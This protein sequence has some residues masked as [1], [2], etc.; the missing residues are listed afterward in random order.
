MIILTFLPGDLITSL[1]VE[2]ESQNI[3]DDFDNDITE[4]DPEYPEYDPE[5][6]EYD[7]QPIL[8][9]RYM[10]EDCKSN[11]NKKIK[12]GLKSFNENSQQ[13]TRQFNT[14]EMVK[15]AKK[16]CDVRIKKENLSKYWT[17]ED[18][19]Y[20]IR[21]LV[22]P[23]IIKFSK[24]NQSQKLYCDDFAEE[25]K[26]QCA[27]CNRILRL[28]SLEAHVQN[29]HEMNIDK[30]TEEY[31]DP[32]IVMTG[33]IENN[34]IC[35]CVSIYHKC[36]ICEKEMA[37]TKQ[38]VE[39]HVQSNHSINLSSYIDNYMKIKSDKESEVNNSNV[40]KSKS[41]RRRITNIKYCDDSSSDDEDN[42]EK[43]QLLLDMTKKK[44][45]SSATKNG[46]A[47][48]F[49]KSD[50]STN[51]DKLT[52][53][54]SNNYEDCCKIE[55]QICFQVLFVNYL[56]GHTQSK[57][58][59][60][61]AS[62]KKKFGS[63]Y[64]YVVKSFHKCNICG[65]EMLF[66][67]DTIATHVRNKH[68]TSLK[69]Y[70][71]KYMDLNHK[72]QLHEESESIK[73]T[74]KLKKKK[75]SSETHK[76]KA[77]QLVTSKEN[78]CDQNSSSKS[79]LVQNDYQWFNGNTFSCKVCNFKST[80]LDNF[81]WH[82]KVDHNSTLQ[83]FLNNY[84][85]TMVKYE[86]KVCDQQIDHE[87]GAIK[88]HLESHFLS[89]DKYG[90]MYEKKLIEMKEKEKQFEKEKAKENNQTKITS[91]EGINDESTSALS[92]KTEVEE[93]KNLGAQNAKLTKQILETE[94]SQSLAM[95]TPAKIRIQRSSGDSLGTIGSG[96]ENEDVYVYLCP[97]PDCEFTTDF[98]VILSLMVKVDYFGIL[99]GYETWAC[100]R[101][102]YRGSSNRALADQTTWT[103]VEESHFGE[104]AVFHVRRCVIT[105]ILENL[106]LI[107]DG[108]FM[109]INILS[110][111]GKYLY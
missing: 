106:F 27:I 24:Q 57:H 76:D 98:Q 4:Y 73:S 69:D 40:V 37:M 94:D 92:S 104:K 72:R 62:Y 17:E 41:L 3:T 30:Y 33:V 16:R 8:N 79:K 11:E 42:K 45:I 101:A 31:G 36:K 99:Q 15:S 95:K 50:K 63:D 91:S 35:S 26:I 34:K 21:N 90:T 105:G 29:K 109:V 25:C 19:P 13:G 48:N 96:S 59:I 44:E 43:D 88:D 60:D 32:E 10:N 64:T 78:K 111:S 46:S 9:K 12:L 80:S 67:Q 18:K 7:P 65:S 6:P 5:F 23:S 71:F 81:K 22:K 74:S 85:R 66:D 14:K 28:S 75:Y 58:Q 2:R 38:I 52:R 61:I 97:F 103:E 47:D 87:K 56:R 110:F 86:C 70:N 54:Y 55:C 53:K 82:V 83:K 84:L 100:C 93:S 77:D 39:D 108:V 102:L 1:N 68:D 107:E 51:N 89:L 20:D 49:R